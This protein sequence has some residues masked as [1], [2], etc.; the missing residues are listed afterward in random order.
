MPDE[1]ILPNA[2]PWSIRINPRILSD[3]TIG[4]SDGLTVPFA[5][6]AGL[7]TL[8]NTR[9]V[10]YGGVAEL[11]AGSISMG[12][13]GYLGAK[14]EAESY[15]ATQENTRRKIMLEPGEINDSIKSILHDTGIPEALADEL[16]NHLVSGNEDK[17]L[18]F[19]M[20]FDYSLSE[21]PTNRAF[22]C[23]LTIAFG[24][25]IGGFIPLL[26]YFFVKK[27]EV[28]KG[29]VWS[30][31]IMAVTL[32]A[33]GYAKTAVVHGWKGWKRCWKG[34]KGAI[35]MVLFYAR[36]ESEFNRTIPHREHPALGTPSLHFSCLNAIPPLAFV[37]NKFLQQY[38]KMSKSLDESYPRPDFVRSRLQWESLNGPWDFFFD[39]G[40]VG[41]SNHWHKTG[42]PEK[43]DF[44]IESSDATTTSTA[45]ETITAQI[46]ANPEKLKQGN[47][48][49]QHRSTTT[50]TK[51]SIIVPY[52]F[53]A[54]ASGINERAVHEVLWYER[55]ITDPRTDEEVAKHYKTIL[56]FGA[57]DYEATVWLN[58]QY[59]GSHTGGHVPFDI[60]VTDAINGTDNRL[61]LRVYDS[62]YDLTQPRGKQYW[63]AKPESI[64]YTPSGG[65]WQ[66]VWLESVPSVRLAD[67]SHGTVLRSSDIE[68]GIL[69]SEI[70]VLG[71]QPGHHYSV[72]V[73]AS[74][75]NVVLEPSRQDLPKEINRVS[76]D[77][78]LHLTE[79][80]QDN[81]LHD[82]K[83]Q[84]FQ[85]P[86]AW[87]NG[88]ALWSPDFP[89]LYKL[90]IRLYTGETLLD[91]VTTSTG[92]RSLNWST[93][94]GTFLLN[95]LPLF[96]A[97]N[98]DQG[99]WPETLMTPPSPSACR[100]DII[101]AKNMG[102]NGCRKHQ[103]LEDPVFL[104]HAD[105]LGYL[106]W[107][108][109]GNAYS[110]SS[111]YA[112]RFNQ[113]WTEAVKRDINHAC[114]VAWT[115]VNESWG[116]PDLKGSVEQR[117][118]IRSLY[119]LT[120]TLDATRPVNDNCGWEHVCTDLTTFHDY[121]DGDVLAG[122]CK[123]MEGIL[124]KKAGRAVFVE[125]IAD[126]D[127]GARHREGAVVLCTEFGGV[128]I[129][130]AEKEGYEDDWGYTTAADPADLLARIEKLVNAVVD[131]GHCAG[132]VWTQLT[133]IEQETN[134]LYSWDRKEKLEAAK[135]KAVMD[136]AKEKYFERLGVRS[137]KTY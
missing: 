125:G 71:W 3:A 28:R 110:Y 74:F 123:T 48:N 107:S 56:R 19:L 76:V 50:Q 21:P 114:I 65:I 68:N 39:D 106:V 46:A 11:I 116:Y 73:E 95:N 57:V 120:K 133:D 43:I 25:L 75:G 38:L 105:Q 29:L 89:N 22:A 37:R 63:G 117:N 124:D 119:Y 27:E 115:P 60:D 61:T 96:Q 129:A 35:E 6:A 17:L 44:E 15:Y 55:S 45:S 83:P 79:A 72:E 92:M 20:R 58:G 59:V 77:V 36:A 135:V 31:V 112:S 80:Q 16:K 104:H 13:G 84:I 8:G 82:N 62:A 64:F 87:K 86:R 69:H 109:M 137:D 47:L 12:L 103:K 7:S 32:F 98:L 102:L 126:K 132:F 121:S 2:N 52:V 130:P 33:F 88:L 108:E 128:N 93:S 85:N 23:A 78:D 134:G 30:S 34:V 51:R 53:Q 136:S 90:T 41:L 14:G 111:L 100:T 18:S 54:P 131:G 67:S 91:E 10:V 99:Y 24:Y 5:L 26:P 94:N 118:H 81:L 113:E 66:N 49:Q 101:L 1:K 9:L 97:L 127:E 42:L 70:A 40:D 122:V 4:L